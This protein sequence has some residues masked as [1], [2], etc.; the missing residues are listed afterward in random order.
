MYEHYEKHRTDNITDPELRQSRPISTISGWD[1]ERDDVN[2]HSQNQHSQQIQTIQ[3]DE[4]TSIDVRDED[5]IEA[6]DKEEAANNDQQSY[7]QQ[8]SLN[9]Q[10]Q[11]STISNISDVYN[12][13]I[14]GGETVNDINIKFINDEQQ[15]QFNTVTKSDMNDDNK[16]KEIPQEQL[17]NVD[18]HNDNGGDIKSV[19]KNEIDESREIATE[20]IAEILQKSEELLDDCKQVADDLLNQHETAVIKDEEL[21]QAVHEV[22]SGVRQIQL[23]SVEEVEKEIVKEEGVELMAAAK[24]ENEKKLEQEDKETDI[25]VCAI[26]NDRKQSTAG[27]SDDDERISDS[28]KIV[29][30]SKNEVD[31][32]TI[33][34]R[35]TSIEVIVNEIIDDCVN[36]FEINVMEKNCNEGVSDLIENKKYNNEVKE[37]NVKDTNN[38]DNLKA[39]NEDVGEI[40]VPEKHVSSKEV[41]NLNEI[42]ERDEK[43]EKDQVNNQYSI[44]G[45]ENTGLIIEIKNKNIIEDENEVRQVLNEVID[46]AVKEFDVDSKSIEKQTLIQD[47]CYKIT[48]ECDLINNNI[49]TEQSEQHEN[50]KINFSTSNDSA[51]PSSLSDD[52]PINENKTNNSTPSPTV[53]NDETNIQEN[54]QKHHHHQHHNESTVGIENQHKRQKSTSSRPMFSPGPT[55]PP[56]RIPEFKWSYIHQRLLSDVLFSLETDIQVWRSHSTKSVLDFVNS[57]E[58]AIFVVNTVHLISQ[59]ADNLIIACG[60]LLPLLASATSPNS[61]LD[62]LEPTQG[63]PLDVAVSFLQRLVNMAD[64]LVFASSLNFGELEA[65]KNMSSGGILRQCLR[66]VSTCAVRNCLECKERTRNAYNGTSLR[67]IP[68]SALEALIRGAQTSSPKS[69]VDSLSG[70]LSPVKDP[71]KLLQDMDV[72]RLR[73][74]IYRDVVSKSLHNTESLIYEIVRIFYDFTFIIIHVIY[75]FSKF[76]FF[77]FIFS[78]EETKQAQF[79][80]LAIV[81]FISVLMVSKYRDILEPPTEIQHQ[82]SSPIMARTTPTPGNFFSLFMYTLL[83]FKFGRYK[84]LFT[85]NM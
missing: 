74:V 29:V 72:N 25:E 52:S 5:N 37:E 12:K 66:L 38:E 31:E 60:G 11:K 21:E 6:I 34:A 71:E 76:F 24:S 9:D 16:L 47:N 4:F 55:R 51:L 56:F 77:Y 67:E 68:G 44:N 82:R 15:Q 30:E 23:K 57:A 59:L 40:K 32:H 19:I 35:P 49:T 18:F 41:N 63:M 14:N 7:D 78:Q 69:I 83:N 75:S 73:A 46:N 26:I 20:M 22:V 45:D 10:S 43:I 58:N 61:E 80:S 42:I 48:N 3:S 39:A 70:P 17:G 50:T 65:E 33:T 8:K 85:G 79:L 84:I 27:A 1:Q 62:V 2:I 64:V 13:E 53:S 36:K 28:V 81:Y 54:L